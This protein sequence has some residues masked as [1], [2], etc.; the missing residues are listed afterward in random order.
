MQ[1]IPIPPAGTVSSGKA[2][3]SGWGDTKKRLALSEDFD[4]AN[5]S[6]VLLT[7][8][9]D[10]IPRDQC[11]RIFSETKV[12]DIVWWSFKT[13]Y[14][15]NQSVEKHADTLLCVGDLKGGRDHCQGDS[16]GPLVCSR[17]K[18]DG[19]MEKYLCGVVSSG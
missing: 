18:S 8:E 6:Q 16:G 3:V 17:K 12:V 1:P 11:D 19:K 5:S 2:R 9:V 7:A 13:N 10:I 15:P 4:R 14:H